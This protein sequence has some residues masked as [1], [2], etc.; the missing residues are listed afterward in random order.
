MLGVKRTSIEECREHVAGS[1]I[2]MEMRNFLTY[3]HAIYKPGP[4][5]NMII[6]PNGTGKSTIVCAIALG[7][8]NNANVNSKK[9]CGLSVKEKI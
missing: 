1:I 7:L 4:Q 9:K 2:R 8:A 3:D 5:L 6:G